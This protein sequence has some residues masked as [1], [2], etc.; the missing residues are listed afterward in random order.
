MNATAFSFFVGI[1]VLTLL[2]TYFAAKKNKST[3]EFY[4]AGGNITGWQNGLAIAGDYMSAASF[5]GIAGAIALNGFSGF[6]YSIGY[7][8][9]YLVV[10]LIVAEPL[11]NLGKYTMADMI[12]AR[13]NAK[14]IRSAA[15]LNT[16]AISTFYMIAQ[17][18]G[19]GAIIKL[20]LGLEY[21]TSVII[22]GILMTVYVV[23]GGMLA[24]TWVQIVKAVLLMG[25]TIALSLIVLAHFSFNPVELFN[26]VAAKIGDK[27]VTPPAPTTF[28][29][30]LDSIS[31]NLALVLGTA[32]LPHILIRFLSVPDAKTARKSIVFATWIIGLF[33]LMTPILGYGAAY[34]VGQDSIK[35]AN[36][37]GNLAA[38][39]L[40]AYLGGDIFLAF[41]S[42][43]AFATILAVVAGLV[44]SAASAFA[45][46]FYSNVLRKG[47][48]SEAEQMKAA[49][50]ASIGIAVFSIVLAL[51]AKSF[52]VSYLVALAFCVAASANLPVIVLTIFWKRFNTTGAVTAML[53]GLIGSVGLI[54]ISPNI[55]PAADAIFPLK[56]PGIVSIPLGF[57][58]AYLGTVLSGKVSE[59]EEEKYTEIFVQANT[60]IKQL[61]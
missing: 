40:A 49:R 60:G 46:D 15:A 8:V 22:I 6:F 50:W 56:N 11:R 36:A 41:I 21:S 38:P 58:A 59:Q 48:A 31:L 14:A 3:S 19:A 43:V 23:A 24:T 33:Y 13:F 54:L 7:L 12:A 37:A 2:I 35:K 55:M 18:V 34:F 20:L 28:T 39:Q 57:L 47:Q 45:H 5:L 51:G 29:A 27:A 16:L 9:A 42:A 32:G 17:L 52:N 26:Q 25:G 1:I 4:V 53:T 10:L 61:G 30:G 44:I